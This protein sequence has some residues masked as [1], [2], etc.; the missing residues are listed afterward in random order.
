MITVYKIRRDHSNETGFFRVSVPEAGHSGIGF[1]IR[2]GAYV[3]GISFVRV[4]KITR[5][6]LKPSLQSFVSSVVAP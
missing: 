4:R 2:R 3:Y 1:Q 5:S 6:T